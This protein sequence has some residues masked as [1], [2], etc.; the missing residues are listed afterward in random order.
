MTGPES[1]LATLG[2]AWQLFRILPEPIPTTNGRGAETRAEPNRFTASGP[3]QFK[4]EFQE[5]RCCGSFTRSRQTQVSPSNLCIAPSSPIALS[6]I[7]VPQH[8]RSRRSH[9]RRGLGSRLGAPVLTQ[10]GRGMGPGSTWRSASCLPS[11]FSG[12]C[13]LRHPSGGHV[14]GLALRTSSCGWRCG[15][16]SPGVGARPRRYI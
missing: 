7:R 13:L 11:Q 8:R 5:G 9:G 14:S 1:K 16:T 12:H 6:P 15:R 3:L 4:E 10:P 2:A